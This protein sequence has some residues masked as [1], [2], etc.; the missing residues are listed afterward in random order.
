MNTNTNT[1]IKCIYTHKI[2]YIYIYRNNMLDIIT[3]NDINIMLTNCIYLQSS[4]SS[5]KHKNYLNWIE[6]NSIPIHL[7]FNAIHFSINWIEFNG[8]RANRGRRK[9]LFLQWTDF[10]VKLSNNTQTLWP[11]NIHIVRAKFNIYEGMSKILLPQTVIPDHGINFSHSLS[12]SWVSRK[13]SSS[14][15]IWYDMIWW[16]A[17]DRACP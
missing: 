2:S 13:P 3:E 5:K 17:M 15:R 11:Q 8:S 10:E 12:K 1:T 14:F 6:F 4:S 16:G 9:L 7:S